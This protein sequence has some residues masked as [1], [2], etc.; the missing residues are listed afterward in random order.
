MWNL[1]RNIHLNV[2][3]GAILN[4]RVLFASC[5]EIIGLFKKMR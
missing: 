5:Q 1:K 2:K 4:K 3:K